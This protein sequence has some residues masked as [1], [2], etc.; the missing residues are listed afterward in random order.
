MQAGLVDHA[1]RDAPVAQLG[2][3]GLD[4]RPA[5]AEPTAPAASERTLPRAPRPPAGG[6]EKCRNP[7]HD[8]SCFV[9]PVIQE[10]KRIEPNS[11]LDFVVDD[12]PGIG[13]SYQM[14]GPMAAASPSLSITAGAALSTASTQVLTRPRR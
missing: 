10:G 4:Q 13:R 7:E 9:D 3:R 14:T 1:G 6:H 2:R 11:S 5:P 8:P 12:L